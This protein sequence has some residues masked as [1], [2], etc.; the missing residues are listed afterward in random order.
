[1]GLLLFRQALLGL[2]RSSLSAETLEI[3]NF[4]VAPFPIGAENLYTN[5]DAFIADEDLRSGD[6]LFNSM[7]AFAAK[8]AVQLNLLLHGGV[9]SAGARDQHIGSGMRGF[10]GLRTQISRSM[11]WRLLATAE[12]SSEIPVPKACWT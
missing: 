2:I 8:R 6:Q 11:S 5:V 1:M 3:G 9:S 4:L 7:L 12:Q 10:K